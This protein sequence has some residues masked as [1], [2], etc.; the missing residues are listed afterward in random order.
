M[1]AAGAEGAGDGDEHVVDG[2]VVRSL[3][4]SFGGWAKTV[5][6][7]DAPSARGKRASVSLSASANADGAGA[8]AGGASSGDAAAP[9][10]GGSRVVGGEIFVSEAELRSRG[11]VDAAIEAEVLADSSAVERGMAM[12]E[13]VLALPSVAAAAAATGDSTPKAPEVV[14]AAMA[15]PVAAAVAPA[16]AAVGAG[17]AAGGGKSGKGGKGK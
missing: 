9:S 7:G 11:G 4:A 6:S 13:K 16:P 14:S 1:P 2:K 12:R 5:L 15:A 10:F 3:K 8:G 17:R